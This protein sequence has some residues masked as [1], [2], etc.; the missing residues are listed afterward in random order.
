[1]FVNKDNLIATARSNKVAVCLGFQDF[2]QLT[3]DY[4]DKES[5]IF[6]TR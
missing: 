4:G 6:N 3:R 2:S 5:K 1:M